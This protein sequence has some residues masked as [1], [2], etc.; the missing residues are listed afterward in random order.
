MNKSIRLLIDEVNT[1]NSPSCLTYLIGSSSNSV[2]DQFDPIIFGET[3]LPGFPGLFTSL[4]YSLLTA[5]L[6]PAGHRL[7]DRGYSNSKV[8]HYYIL[9]IPN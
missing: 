4:V 1:R 8:L 3:S 6:V 7:Y 2:F 5:L 9:G